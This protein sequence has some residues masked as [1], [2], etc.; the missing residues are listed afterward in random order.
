MESA[1]GNR[2]S[3]QTETAVIRHDIL[4]NEKMTS[5]DCT[6]ID[7]PYVHSLMQQRHGVLHLFPLALSLGRIDFIHHSTEVPINRQRP[8]CESDVRDD[9]NN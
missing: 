6:R 2:P 7:L 3:L 4:G 1:L 8:S 9:S 5:H